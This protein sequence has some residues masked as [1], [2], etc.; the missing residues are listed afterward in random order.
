MSWDLS[1]EEIIVSKLEGQQQTI[2]MFSRK[3]KELE[4]MVAATEISLKIATKALEDAEN[5]LVCL[6]IGD[7]SELVESTYKIVNV[8]LE[9]LKHH[10][11]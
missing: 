8:A 5:C 3:I 4:A 10:R 7:P 11:E 2:M 9:T 6:P 1:S